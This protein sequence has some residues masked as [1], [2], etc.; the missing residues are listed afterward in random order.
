MKGWLSV[1]QAAARL[2]VKPATLY[3]YVSRGVVGRRRDADGRSLFDAGEI[4]RLARRG[5]PRR[6][7]GPPELVIESALTELGKDRQ[8]YRGRDATELAG[9]CELEDIADWLWTAEEDAL[10][11]TDRP[12]WLAAPDAVA[13]ARAAQATLPAGVLPLE[14]LQVALP[15]LA[16]HDPL[17]LAYSESSVVDIGQSMIA[18][19][20]ECLPGA[21]A[22]GPIAARLWPKLTTAAPRPE[23]VDLIRAALVLTADHELAASTH[24]VRVAA[25]VR[26]DPYA[27]VSTGLGATS[28]ALHGG[29]SLGAEALLAEAAEPARAKY[30]MGQRLRRGERIPGFGHQVYK[31]GDHRGTT[32]LDRIRAA[33]PDHPRLAVADAVI[34]EARRRRLPAFNVDF[35]LAVLADVTG[36][37]N[38][39]GEAIFAIART[40]GWLA[41]A[42]EEYANP[43]K[44]RLRA[45]YLYGGYRA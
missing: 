20:V 42:M 4:E 18:G 14:R 16:V 26:A 30:V 39:A 13:A 37:V 1:E 9:W 19:M 43:T 5:R 29:A 40:V 17:R 10:T 34:D 11:R 28:G 27:V 6:S 44:V 25:A 24:A 15:V 22:A 23:L 38:G 21:T 45:S 31:S 7:S 3:A 12:Q 33:A 36:M 32:L 2:G 41:H 35:A 8:R